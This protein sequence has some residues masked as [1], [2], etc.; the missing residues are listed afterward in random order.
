MRGRPPHIP[1]A[2]GEAM[3]PYTSRPFAGEDDYERM[4]GL[5]RACYAQTPDLACISV[6]DLDWWRGTSQDPRNIDQAQLWFDQ[7]GGLAGFAWPSGE[8]VN[9]HTLPQ[10]AAALDEQMLAWSEGWR[11]AQPAPEDGK[12]LLLIAWSL[13]AND[14][15]NALYERRGYTRSEKAMIYRRRAAQGPLPEPPLPQGYRIRHVRGEEDLERR[16]AVHR[17]AFAPS[18]MTVEKHRM[19][20]GL[21]TYRPELDLVAEAPDESF[22]SFCIVWWDE[23][24]RLGVFEPVGCHSEHRRRGLTKALMAEGL[25]RLQ[26]LG[27]QTAVVGSWYANDA[28]N[29]LYESLGFTE[30]C[31]DCAW[32]RTLAPR[33]EHSDDSAA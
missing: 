10:H 28:S 11:L 29:A 3:T 32:D 23:P 12:P 1:P 13:T 18:R 4:R 5:L 15:R 9:L 24:S 21:P 30:F 26:A 7:G 20:M 33:E 22:A 27:A 14:Q 16:V 6:G 2:H 31:R 19:V 25:R 8:Q 17:D